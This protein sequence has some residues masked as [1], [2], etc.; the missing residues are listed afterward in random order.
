M[1]FLFNEIQT[2]PILIE[3]DIEYG[4]HKSISKSI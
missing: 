2:M 1:K 3:A 4:E